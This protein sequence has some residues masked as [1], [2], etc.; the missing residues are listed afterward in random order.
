MALA[1]KD[2]YGT[3]A[4]IHEI[5]KIFRMLQKNDIQFLDSDGNN[6]FFNEYHTQQVIIVDDKIYWYPS[7]YNTRDYLLVDLDS[8]D[9][10]RTQLNRRFNLFISIN[11]DFKI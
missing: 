2:L 8:I 11:L 1:L 7:D 4:I 6:Q 5:D 9:S 3:D 10:V